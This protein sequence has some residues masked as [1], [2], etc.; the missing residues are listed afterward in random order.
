MGRLWHSA[1]VNGFEWGAEVRETGCGNGG[2]LIIQV[3]MFW[4]GSAWHVVGSGSGGAVVV[5]ASWGSWM[6]D[7]MKSFNKNEKNKK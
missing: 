4:W 2:G 1:A 6:F 7:E 5:M 3:G